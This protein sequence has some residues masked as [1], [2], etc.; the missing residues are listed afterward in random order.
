MLYV[1]NKKINIDL[2]GIRYYVYY[3]ICANSYILRDYVQHNCF[4]KH[5]SSLIC[6]ENC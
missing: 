5:Q 3:V 4:K 6:I 2:C 1:I